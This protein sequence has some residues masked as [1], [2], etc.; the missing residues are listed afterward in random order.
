MILLNNTMEDNL[1]IAWDALL[2]P[3]K[4][5]LLTGN[6]GTGKSTLIKKYIEHMQGKVIVLAPTGTAAVDIGGMT[7]HRFFHFPARP[8]S[9][10]AVKWLN[11]SDELDAAK[12]DLIKSAAAIVIDEASM[13][14]ADI[15]DQIAWFFE[16]NF[17]REKI[18]PKTRTKY[19]P[20][21][22]KK[23]ILVGDVDQ[24]PPVVKEGAEKEMIYTRYKSEFFFHAHCWIPERYSSFEIIKLTKIWRQTDPVFINLLNDI[25]NNK[26]TP[27]DLDRL[28]NRCYKDGILSPSDGVMICSTN[29]IATEVNSLMIQRLENE[30][31]TFRGEVKGNFD[32]RNCTI[33]SVLN[34]KIGCRLMTMRNS[35][36]LGY[37]NGSIGTLIGYDDI[38]T[39]LK[40]KLDNGNEVEIGKHIFENVEFEYNKEADKI[41]HKVTGEFMQYP[42]RL[43][44]A[45]TV[46][47]SQGKTFDKV[48]IDMGE[49][50]AFAHGQVYVAL[51][52]CRSLEGI[53]IRRPIQ[54]KELIYNKNVLEFNKLIN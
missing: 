52:R 45:I 35:P 8:I 1:S 36:N 53:I 7:I 32:P 50:G 9:F 20:F 21:G 11:P 47:K 25:K 16:K 12:I 41:L 23:I 46:H 37:C 22:G 30:E 14:R 27:F 29:A 43:A 39:Y 28:N 19:G 49:S 33:E 17:P 24:L 5:I 44:Y 2:E 31:I 10:A 42:V 4:N 13:I 6:A 18:N 26:L 38:T 3:T 51:S 48:I 34:L 54:N 40:I 15:M